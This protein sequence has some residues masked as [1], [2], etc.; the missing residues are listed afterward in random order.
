MVFLKTVLYH[1]YGA[2]FDNVVRLCIEASLGTRKN[3][4]NVHRYVICLVIVLE[5]RSASRVCVRHHYRS[6]ERWTVG[7]IAFLICWKCIRMWNSC[8]SFCCVW[9]YNI[10]CESVSEWTKRYRKGRI[11]LKVIQKM[12]IMSFTP[13]SLLCGILPSE[14]IDGGRWIFGALEKDIRC[15]QFA[16]HEEVHAWVQ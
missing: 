9:L 15:R 5:V 4:G 10:S 13:L 7:S 1:E 16:S 3:S 6:Q 14:K 2:K 12:L 8:P 11:S